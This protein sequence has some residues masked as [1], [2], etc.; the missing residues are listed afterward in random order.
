MPNNLINPNFDEHGFI[1]IYTGNGKGKTT[2]AFGLTLRAIGHGW[3]VL[4]LQFMKA[5]DAWQYGEALSVVKYP[6]NIEIKQFGFNKIGKFTK[7]DEIHLLNG[8]NY[9]KTC[10]NQESGYKMIILDE[11][12][13]LIHQNII[14]V[15]EVIKVLKNKTENMEIVITGRHAHPKL[16]EIADLITT[17]QPTKHYYPKVKARCGIEY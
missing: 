5:S 2:A 13:H 11:L 16:I 9:A 8:W 14:S 7:E 3:K 4:I 12:N 10:I 6:E 15:D 17:M 1:Q